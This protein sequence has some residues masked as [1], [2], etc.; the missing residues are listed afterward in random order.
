MWKDTMRSRTKAAAVIGSLAIV[1]TLLLAGCGGDSS[2]TS[3]PSSAPSA[4]SWNP[5]RP[6]GLGQ[7]QWDTEFGADPAA[8]TPERLANACSTNEPIGS[9]VIDAITALYPGSTPEEWKALADYTVAYLTP[10]CANLPSGA[11]AASTE[12]EA[13]ESDMS[14]ENESVG[15]FAPVVDG[16]VSYQAWNS[17]AGDGAINLF[18]TNTG[19]APLSRDGFFIADILGTLEDGSTYPLEAS[20]CGQPTEVPVGDYFLC[21]ASGETA[22][23]NV[24]TQ[25]AL[26]SFSGDGSTVIVPVNSAD[27]EEPAYK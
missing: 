23:G 18:I 5:P 24:Y 22:T 14:S 9:D 7:E 16:D 20:L 12:D 3:A 8:M 15:A 2:T 25:I 10:L 27:I 11:A 4:A 19:A 21:S 6:T 26:P 13:V 17:W 1:G